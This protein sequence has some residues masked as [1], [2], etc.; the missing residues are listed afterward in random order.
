MK[1]YYDCI[2]IGGGIIGLSIAR[3]MLITEP[4]S[5]VLIIEKENGF[6][7]HASG[8]NSGVLHS[9]IYYPSNSIKSSVCSSGSKEMI[10]FC[11]NHNIPILHTGKVILPIKSSHDKYIDLLHNRANNNGI[12]TFIVNDKELHEI[13]P[14]AKSAS[15]RALYSPDT[16][17]IDPLSVLNKIIYELNNFATILTNSIVSSYFP[18]ESKIIVNGREVKYGQLY[19]S[20]GLYADKIAHIFSAGK[21]YVILPFK[22]SYYKL[23][24]NCNISIKKL[25]YPV[26]NLDYP[27]L[28]IHSVTTID[29]NTLLGPSSIPVFGRENYTGIKGINPF[30]LFSIVYHLYGKYTYDSEF[31]NFTHEEISKLSKKRFIS[32]AKAIIPKLNSKCLRKSDK[33]GIRAQLYNTVDKQMEMDFV[34]ERVDNTIHVL[35]AVSPAFTSAFSMAKLITKDN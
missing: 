17:V 19:N 3:E 34:I 14:E 4:D 33:V 31:R 1:D 5:S 28:G 35:N 11:H 20:A 29:G 27:F 7:L 30:D 2:I 15:G 12:N 22:G 32:S 16:A 23:L 10:N 9:G 13:E 24:D 26:P 6:G 18:D 25:I 8:R 21:E